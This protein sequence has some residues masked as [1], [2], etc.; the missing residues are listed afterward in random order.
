MDKYR[1][2]A[3]KK[4]KGVHPDEIMREALEHAAFSS[5]ERE[6][7]FDK[8]YGDILVDCFLNFLSNRTSRSQEA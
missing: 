7:F 5:L 4:L 6:H 8:V 2:P 1:G 3:E